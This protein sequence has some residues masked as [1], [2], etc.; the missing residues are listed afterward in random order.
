MLVIVIFGIDKDSIPR[1]FFYSFGKF[2]ASAYLIG[3]KLSVAHTLLEYFIVCCDF[4]IIKIKG[5]PIRTNCFHLTLMQGNR[6]E[7]FITLLMRCILYHTVF[8]IANLTPFL[9]GLSL[10]IENIK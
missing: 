9:L 3:I 10:E 7:Y 8:F 4:L 6:I 5:N 1:K 2:I